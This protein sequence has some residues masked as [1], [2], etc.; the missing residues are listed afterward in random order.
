MQ[1]DLSASVPDISLEI[2]KA[3]IADGKKYFGSGSSENEKRQS[4]F[5]KCTFSY[6]SL[7]VHSLIAFTGVYFVFSLL[8]PGDLITI[9]RFVPFEHSTRNFS[10]KSSLNSPKKE[11]PIEI[12][13]VLVSDAVDHSCVELL[14]SNGISVDYKL[15][16]PESVL[17]D[18]AKV[19]YVTGL[20]TCQDSRESRLGR[21]GSEQPSQN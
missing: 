9:S 19:K 18:E 4:G 17:I 16:L 20:D 10:E 5:K 7:L 3:W 12:K 11:M 8:S 21:S 13:N 14:E 2:S 6:C 15:K 1:S